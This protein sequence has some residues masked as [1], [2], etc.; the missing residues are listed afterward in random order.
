MI[1]WIWNPINLAPIIN[2]N[3]VQPNRPVMMF[4]NSSKPIDLPKITTIWLYINP[5]IQSKRPKRK[6]VLACGFQN[7]NFKNQRLKISFKEII[8]KRCNS[9]FYFWWPLERLDYQI[10]WI[11]F[12]PSTIYS[13]LHKSTNLIASSTVSFQTIS[14]F[15]LKNRVYLSQKSSFL[16]KNSIFHRWYLLEL[17][18]MEPMMFNNL[19]HKREVS[20]TDSLDDESDLNDFMK[21]RVPTSQNTFDQKEPIANSYTGPYVYFICKSPT[22]YKLGQSVFP[23]CIWSNAHDQFLG[24][25]IRDF[26]DIWI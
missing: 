21:V 9:L 11:H 10:V 6:I 3:V 19:P 1:N 7:L 20:E 17:N 16:G 2:T 14:P 18:K 23:V 26:D 24:H 15:R 5:R 12:S 13:V 8:E 25:C 4:K 22:S